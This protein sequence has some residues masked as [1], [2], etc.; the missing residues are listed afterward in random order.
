MSFIYFC[1]NKSKPVTCNLKPATHSMKK[2]GVFTSGGDSP[3]MN[4]AIRA[5]VRGAVFNGLEV[6]GINRGY[7]GLMDNDIVPLP[8]SAVSNI[9]Q[10][11][12]TILKTAR[13][14]R[15]LTP[16]GRKQAYDHLKANGID[17]LVALGGDGTFRGALEFTHEYPDIKIAGAPCTID[18]DL[19]GTDYTIG[20]DTAIN[21][22]VDAIDKIRDT[23][24]SHDRLFFVEVMGRDAGFIAL[25][26]GIGSGAEA[27]LVP[28][29]QT[30]VDALI[31][32]LD[33]GRE[34]KSSSIV[35]VAEG[36]DAGGAF[37]IAKMV[38]AKLDYYDIKVTVLGHIQRGGNPSC[39]DRV[40]ASRL[41]LACVDALLEGKNNVMAGLVNNEIVYTPFE[42]AVK[43]HQELNVNMLR[44]AEVLSI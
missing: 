22:A 6:M 24:V 21:T 37:D 38:K 10:R 2:I 40:L 16:E 44:L 26:S 39:M 32:K 13:S 12:G 14:K 31:S 30:D 35:V 27:I 29:Y 17:S 18:N 1:L 8:S 34:G 42:K 23:A 4:A 41:G 3:G 36:D 43:Y 28:E 19:Y 20:F 5:V 7:E 11:G 9:I 25:L 33:K 15:F